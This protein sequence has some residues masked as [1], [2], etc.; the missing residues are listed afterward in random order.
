MK[1]TKGS[2]W[3]VK[4]MLDYAIVKYGITNGYSDSPYSQRANY[5]R[6]IRRTLESRMM[7]EQDE[8]TDKYIYVL[9]EREAKYFID[10]ILRTYFE[11]RS[12]DLMMEAKYAKAD[13][14]LNE[15]NRKAVTEDL[16]D[17]SYENGN[18]DPTPLTDEINAAIDRLMLRA[19]F[20][21]FYSFNEKE[22]R[23]DFIKRPDYVIDDVLEPI[24]EGY[25]L[26]N[27]KLS[28]PVKYYCAKK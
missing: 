26:L 20:E 4:Q 24:L 9:T 11:E 6:K 25:S 28:N 2:S 10:V 1:K 27:E 14:E 3:T 19:I 8:E 5:E 16:D 21:K 22:Y 23:R 7:V 15:N 13:A 18:P 17:Y 12:E